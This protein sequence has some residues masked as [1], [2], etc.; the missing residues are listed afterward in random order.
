MSNNSLVKNSN[1][2]DLGRMTLDEL[3]SNAD[4]VL[5]NGNKT[6]IQKKVDNQVVNIEI[7]SYPTGEKREVSY[8]NTSNREDLLQT[9]IMKLKAGESQ[10]DIAF[11]LGKSQSYI[12]KVKN[13]KL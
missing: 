7:T 10:E 2:G 12:S 9:I 13:G 3:R 11:E 8:N 4:K 5:I 1:N 6:K